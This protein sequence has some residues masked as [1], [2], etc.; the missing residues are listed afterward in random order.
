MTIT[1]FDIALYAG[2]LFILFLTPGPVWLATAARTIAHGAGAALPLAL[3]V[4][5][6]DLIWSL[7]AILGLSW[8]VATYSGIM[9]VLKWLAALVFAGM[10]LLLIR[11]ASKSID[12]DS[13]LN[14]P[15]IWAG[16][17][18]GLIAIL[19]NPKAVLF[20]MGM[21]PGFFDLTVLTPMDIAI[22]A[23]I[24]MAVPLIG[25]MGFALFIDRAR[26]LISSPT[27]LKRTNQLAGGLLILV[28]VVIGVLT[29]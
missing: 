25:N 28:A 21:L 20:Y 19:A 18:A 3:G 7:L 27:A 2:A 10:G 23:G 15:G 11:H 13:R 16:F 1:V 8:V 24:S 9:V 22:I 14:R 6:G 29:P 12:A 4:A 26:V 17:F 5:V